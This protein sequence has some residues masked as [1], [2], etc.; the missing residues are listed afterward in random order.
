MK[1]RTIAAA[2]TMAAAAVTGTALAA[3]ASGPAVFQVQVTGWN[4]F[5]TAYP[6]TAG[7]VV[8][9]NAGGRQFTITAV[10][11]AGGDEN[12]TVGT[13]GLPAKGTDLALEL[14]S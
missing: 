1:I 5:R 3:H 8:S 11:T 13:A 10:Q 6:L 4:T 9:E 12:V 2:V 14:V 7:E